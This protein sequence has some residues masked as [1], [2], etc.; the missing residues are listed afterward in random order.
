MNGSTMPVAGSSKPSDPVTDEG[1]VGMAVPV[2]HRKI[3]KKLTKVMR[4]LHYKIQK[5]ETQEVDFDDDDDSSTPFTEL[6]RRIESFVNKKKEFPDYHDVLKL[7]IECNVSSSPDYRMKLAQ[8]AFE[9]V[10][11]ELQRRRKW[12]DWSS[13]SSFLGNKEDPAELDPELN[14]KLHRNY[15]EAKTKISCV[16]NQ[17]ADQEVQGNL[18]PEE[19]ADEDAEQSAGE[20]SG[21]EEEEEIKAVEEEDHNDIEDDNLPS[22]PINTD[23]E[24][25]NL[26]SPAPVSPSKENYDAELATTE[27]DCNELDPSKECLTESFGKKQVF[28]K[29]YLSHEI[30]S[31]ELE[32]IKDDLSHEDTSEVLE[33]I[34]DDLSREN[35]SNELEPIKDV[36]S[37]ENTSDELEP[38]KDDLSRE[39]TNDELEPTKDNLSREN[40]SDELEPM[41][42]DF[43]FFP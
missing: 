15:E 37:H 42:D 6:N 10:G 5:L 35:T 13:V 38:M 16:I 32:P 27:D 3:V 8:E 21:Q 12:D 34:R 19:V 36:F 28:L 18:E 25:S 30:I 1:E 9:I 43:S 14:A 20:G 17:F 40:T 29:N 39:N 33:P 7:V 22:S 31:D 2:E 41:K 23:A 24:S 4:I 26:E 11:N